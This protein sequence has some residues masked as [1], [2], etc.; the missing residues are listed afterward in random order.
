M[1]VMKMKS[2]TIEVSFIPR[3]VDVTALSLEDNQEYTYSGS[4]RRALTRLQQILDKTA[5]AYGGDDDFLELNVSTDGSLT[6]LPGP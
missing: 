2:V 3:T 6:I 5:E 4:T 1:A